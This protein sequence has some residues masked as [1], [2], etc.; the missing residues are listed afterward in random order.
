M[1][2]NHVLWQTWA[3]M[4]KKLSQIKVIVPTRL[5][6]KLYAIFLKRGSRI[7]FL[8]MRG[9]DIVNIWDFPS[10]IS[11]HCHKRLVPKIVV[12]H[13]QREKFLKM[14]LRDQLGC[15]VDYVRRIFFHLLPPVR[16]RLPSHKCFFIVCFPTL[17]AADLKDILPV[18]TSPISGPANSNISAP[19]RF[20][21]GTTYL[22][23]M[24]I[25]KNGI[26]VLSITC[27]RAPN[28]LPLCLPTTL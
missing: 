20:A 5:K 22:T 10:K 3:S 2:R 15:L 13:D 7:N 14:S 24:D 16:L 1:Y 23:K 8:F 4:P 11:R 6:F 12:W 9:Q 18:I 26:A 17:F 19:M 28:P 25:D 27:A 21:A